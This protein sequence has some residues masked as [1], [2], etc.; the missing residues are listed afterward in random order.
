MVDAKKKLLVVMTKSPY[1][2]QTARE[3][4]DAVL[5][6]AAF[7]Q[8]LTLLFLGDGVFQL[9]SGQD[10]TAVQLKNLATTLPVLPMY[11]VENICVDADSLRQ[12]GI[13]ND[14]LNLP[15]TP[16]DNAAV[17]ALFKSHDQILSF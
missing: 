13:D 2:N 6:A 10:T 5:T 11:D 16:V 14:E 4:L 9:L 15:A 1:G 17:R 3:A 8:P 12:R 7:E